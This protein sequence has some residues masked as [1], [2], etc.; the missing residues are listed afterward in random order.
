MS[1]QADTAWHWQPVSISGFPISRAQAG[2]IYISMRALTDF[3]RAN[4]P[5]T[6]GAEAM[7]EMLREFL[8]NSRVGRNAG[9]Y[10]KL[11]RRGHTFILSPDGLVVTGYGRRAATGGSVVAAGEDSYLPVGYIRNELP[12]LPYRMAAVTEQTVRALDPA[13]LRIL[14][15]SRRQLKNAGLLEPQGDAA[16]MAAI[17]PILAHDLQHGNVHTS[18]AGHWVVVGDAYLWIISDDS[19]RLHSFYVR[20]RV[21][22]NLADELLKEACE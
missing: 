22:D 1:E 13:S 17:A 6:S 2:Q 18:P 12:A 14:T 11:S 19:T 9:G 16:T 8:R 21:D 4:N 5:D 15:R 7:K 20:P 3:I 10:W